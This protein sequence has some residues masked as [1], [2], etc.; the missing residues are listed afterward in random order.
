MNI[1]KNQ[2]DEL[3]EQIVINVE[4]ADYA[5][6]EEKYLK[7]AKKTADFK[8]FRKGMVPM[9]LVKR[10]YGER[11]LVEAV[12]KVISDAINDY[13]KNNPKPYFGEPM[14]SDEQDDNVWESGKDF[15]F[16]FDLGYS[17]PIDF[18]I[19]KDDKLPVYEIGISDEAVAEMKANMLSQMGSQQEGEAAGE[20]DF[21]IADLTQEEG[22]NAKNVEGAYIAVRSVEGE[23]KKN[24]LG[25]K[26]GDEFTVNV[27]EAFTNDTDRAAMLKV[28]KEEF[29]GID[30]IFKVK[31][32]NVKTFVPAEESQEVYDNLFGED[33]VHNSEEFDAAVRERLAENY[34]QEADYR[35][36]NDMRDYFTA[37]AGVKL[38]KDF[39]RKFLI[40][41]NEGK[42]TPEQIDAELPQ[43]LT[44]F[45]WRRV[46]GYVLDKYDVKIEQ[47]DLESAA[48]ARVYYQYA[49]YGLSNVPEDF[50]RDAA[51]RML[52]DESQSDVILSMVEDKKCTDV[53][54]ENITLDPVAITVEDF[55]NLQ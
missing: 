10:V 23:A 16:K 26:A 53:L 46:R 5:A 4:A 32:V 11:A 3:S 8:G 41:N 47:K 34:R 40:K 49:M 12:N 19:S 17:T 9:S 36:S 38:P 33:K 13:L 22:E 29:E 1:T 37:K 6:E 35:L 52:A 44:D 50:I 2:I 54:K 55:R 7:S 14:A 51:K 25:A 15:T 39:I 45:A 21:I 20:E 48:I 27:N 30:P 43:F 28:K 24:F 42:F 18:E 31:V